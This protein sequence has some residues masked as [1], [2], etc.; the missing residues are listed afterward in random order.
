MREQPPGLDWHK[1]DTKHFEIVFPKAITA[2]AQA[3]ANTLE[4]LY[5]PLGRTLPGARRRMSVVLE[6]EGIEANGYVMLMPR[7]SA[8]Y[9]TPPQGRFGGLTDWDSELAVH[10]GRHMVQFD[11]HNQGFTRV[12][13]LLSGEAGEAGFSFLATPL[14]FWEGDAVLM[15]T[16]LSRSGR[17]RQ[18]SFDLAVRAPLLAN[19]RY[20]YYKSFL[21]SYKDRT[22]G[23]YDLGYFLVTRARRTNGPFVWSRTIDR[24]SP[25]S[26]WPFA[27]QGALKAE[28]GVGPAALYSDTLNDLKARW[29]AQL[30]GLRLTPF[31][32]LN[33]EPRRT[34]A[35]YVMPVDDGAQ[36]VIAQ[37]LSYD[38]PLALVRIAPD[39]SEK[40]LTQFAPGELYGTRSTAAAGRIVW[41][42][43]VPDW[44]WSGRSYSVVALYD[45][46][47]GRIRR[48]THKT[49]LLNPA[50]SPDGERVVAVELTKERRATLVILDAQT[51]KEVQRLPNPGNDL[52]LAPGWS[53]DGARIVYVRQNTG[54][55]ALSVAACDSGQRRDLLP[56]SR[57][58]IANPELHGRYVF[59]ESSY[60][61]IDNIYALDL[62]DGRRYQV[63]SSHLGAFYP[64]VTRDG[65][66]LLYSDYTLRGHD[67]AEAPLD[68]AGWTPIEQ[69][70][71]RHLSYFEPVVAQEA[72][73]ATLDPEHIPAQEHEV[74]K[75]RPLAHA[76]NVHSWSLVPTTP[77]LGMVFVSRD[78]LATTTVTGGLFY[79]TDERVARGVVVG[80]LNTFF[81]LIDLGV[82]YGGRA[83]SYLV[84]QDGAS[85]EERYSWQE[86]EVYTGL[87]VPLNLSRGV[88]ATSVTFGASAGH[89]FVS[90]K[91]R[92]ALLENGNG[93]LN[94][95]TYFASATHARAGAVR[96]VGL[97]WAQ[98]LDVRYHHTPLGG[99]YRGSLLS[100]GGRLFLPGLVRHQALSVSLG[101]ERQN[102]GNYVFDRDLGFSRG[103]DSYV[104]NRLWLGSLNYRLPVADPD[105]ALGPV[106]YLKR[107]RANLFFDY[108]RG[109]NR[110]HAFLYR[111][112][113][114]ELTF[115]SHFF[116]LPV[117]IEP[118]LRYVYCVDDA[119]SR[120][121]ARHRLEGILGV[122]F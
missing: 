50:I 6:N 119:A 8:F 53:D 118:G 90:G 94:R 25:W 31:Q 21:G 49:R 92:T 100:V 47:S 48:L 14:W 41:N 96:D 29:L 39:G 40:R 28:T 103:Y 88:H 91:G 84:Q 9:T 85:H 89:V 24:V 54:G 65:Q 58:D 122:T 77:S 86:R 52:L 111:S 120:G 93:S 110:Q 67:L 45:Q 4:H 82:A 11:K 62:T 113:G 99:D 107:I 26:F 57:E 117:P 12:A 1:I 81:P 72:G 7:H 20:S 105:W 10:E 23:P 35:S 55:R 87:R 109:S 101:F 60:S 34:F 106:L 51:G 16:V 78:T 5:L 102:P 3:M 64:H 121:R 71:D 17:G 66:R 38:D 13:G 44:R 95:V 76:L 27:F 97:R 59:Y 73:V 61:G 75:Y 46:G 79:E 98:S 32:R 33:A 37:K 69:V 83:D 22:P 30:D 104:H 68:P 56:L 19:R 43:V 114:A 18:P 63:T 80:T 42:E 70:S 36:G 108:G 112:A 15:E 2:E 115:E 74:K 116:S